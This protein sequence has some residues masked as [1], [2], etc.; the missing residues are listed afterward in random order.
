ME[1]LYLTVVDREAPEIWGP[2]KMVPA[3]YMLCDTLV[4][5]IYLF[6]YL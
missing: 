1:E 6:I 2:D 3:V 5:D 4:P